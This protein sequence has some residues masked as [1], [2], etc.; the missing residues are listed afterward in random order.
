MNHLFELLCCPSG[1]SLTEAEIKKAN[2]QELI[3]KTMASSNVLMKDQNL[4]DQA[5]ARL[6]TVLT[7]KSH[8]PTNTIKTVQQMFEAALKGKSGRERHLIEWL[9][10]CV[11][12][13]IHMA[14]L[15][16]E[17]E[18]QQPSSDRSIPTP[19]KKP[20]GTK[21]KKKAPRATRKKRNSDDDAFVVPDTEDDDPPYRGSV[22]SDDEYLPSDD[23]PEGTGLIK[24]KGRPKRG[25]NTSAKK[26]AEDLKND[27]DQQVPDVKPVPA[28]KAGR[29]KR[30]DINDQV[31]PTDGVMV[32][33]IESGAGAGEVTRYF[34]SLTQSAGSNVLSK[35][36]FAKAYF[37]PSKESFNAF[38]SVINSARDCI[39]ICVFSLTD[40]DVADALIAAKKRKVNI[41]IITDNQQAAGKGADAERLQRDHGIPYKTD[42]TTGYMHNK[43]A[44]VDHSTLINGSFNWSKG[45]RFKNREN[46][47]ITNIPYC[48]QE[49][50]RQFESLWEEF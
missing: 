6:K 13:A 3:E 14:F 20:S 2:Y 42:N 30:S 34:T 9:Q 45:A 36:Y 46:I 25:S 38:I 33:A 8:S 12:S 21:E 10:I 49:F 16:D 41:R 43:F 32:P 31:V 17:P 26:T 47:M 24:Q 40:D 44:I 11:S 18:K 19:Q 23:F 22:S 15:I 48:I 4:K 29:K 35:G 50:Q 5:S 39:D 28:K 7:S 1:S 37:F 27:D